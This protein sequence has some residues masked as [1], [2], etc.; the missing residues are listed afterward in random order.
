MVLGNRRERCAGHGNQGKLAQ[1]SNSWIRTCR[2]GRVAAT[3][4]SLESQR[5]GNKS[6]CRGNARHAQAAGRAS[7]W[8][9]LV[10]EG[11]SKLELQAGSGKPVAYHLAH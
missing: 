3:R 2:Q 4:V 9:Q 6:S 8:L 10:E 5:R 1:L 11:A 7:R